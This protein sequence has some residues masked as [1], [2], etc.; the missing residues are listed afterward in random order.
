M[1]C[2]PPQSLRAEFANDL[3]RASK[4]TIQAGDLRIDYSKQMIDE[5]AIARLLNL[6]SAR[7][8]TSAFARMANGERINVTEGRAVGHMALRTPRGEQF[9]I[10]GVDVVPA[11]W[12]V[13]D[14][15]ADLARAIRSGEFIGST[16]RKIRC[17]V[18]IGIGGSDL[19][20][21]MVYEALRG[22]RSPDISCRFVSNVDPSGF[23]WDIRS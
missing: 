3:D 23:L 1:A 14:Q 10:D 18:N 7:G 4:M 16:G 11:V 19:G 13:L 5:I 2:P 22:S 20:P 9:L 12:S 15:M 21:A 6:A 17:V 8:I